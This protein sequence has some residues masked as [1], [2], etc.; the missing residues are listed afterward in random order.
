MNIPLSTLR[1]GSPPHIWNASDR[2]LLVALQILDDDTCSG[3]GQP[4][5]EA[6]DDST[7][8]SYEHRS[9]VCGG[10]AALHEHH[11][12]GEPTPGEK[13]YIVAE[14]VTVATKFAP[15]YD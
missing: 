12:Q 6:W 9:V 14:S 7:P 3:C 13:P 4:I 10:C 8:K 11:T 1:D 2:L 15:I 5:S